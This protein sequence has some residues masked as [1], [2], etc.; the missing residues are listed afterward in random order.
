MQG[1]AKTLAAFEADPYGCAGEL[2]EKRAARDPFADGGYAAG[3]C[4][5]LGALL[6]YCGPQIFGGALPW[7]GAPA[8]PSNAATS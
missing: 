7:D 3:R 6:E 4:P 5:A 8:T 1:E 2:A